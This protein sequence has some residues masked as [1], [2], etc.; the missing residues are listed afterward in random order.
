MIIKILG[1]LDI[2]LG[3]FLFLAIL[4]L[5]VTP[6]LLVGA[7]YLLAKSI[8]FS[9]EK[10]SLGNVLDF[11]VAAIIMLTVFAAMPGIVLFIAGIFLIQKG[12]FSL[13]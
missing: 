7:F 13:K 2:I 8:F 6:V 1:I 11:I 12:F 3:I 10:I 9:L 5:I 4:K